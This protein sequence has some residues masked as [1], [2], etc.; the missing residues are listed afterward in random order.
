MQD[1]LKAAFRIEQDGE[2][3]TTLRLAS[4]LSL[5]QPSVT[6]M[7]KRLDELHL[8][9]HSPYRGIELTDAGRKIALEVIRHHRLLELYLSQ[10]LG[11][12]LDA[13]HAEAE[14]LEHHVSEE[15][16]ARM[17][18]ALGFPE[19]DPH[20]DPI[21]D[22]EGRIPTIADV[23]LTDMTTGQSGQVSRVSDRDRA[24]LQ[25]LGNFG[26]RPGE[27][28]TVI[29]V[30]TGVATTVTMNHEAIELPWSLACL[31]RVVPAG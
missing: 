25:Q 26:L 8:V 29:R 11:Y 23:V 16:E 14:H 2:P 7:V 18:R 9:V 30:T 27:P 19:F 5:S 6:N 13:V 17:E 12:D 10:A 24:L 20:G 31:V 21:P 3:I 1:Y 28:L 15:L 4:A 22:R